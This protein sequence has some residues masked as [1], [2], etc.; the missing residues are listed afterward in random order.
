M[1]FAF[2]T[3]PEVEGA[4][5]QWDDA[6]AKSPEMVAAALAAGFDDAEIVKSPLGVLAADFPAGPHATFRRG[7]RA[8]IGM[9]GSALLEVL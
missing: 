4:A 2:L 6:A 7:A 3:Y 8:L 5:I 9:N 1:K